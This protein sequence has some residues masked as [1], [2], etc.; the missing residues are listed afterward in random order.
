[1]KVLA[2]RHGALG[3]VIQALGPLQ[4]IRRHH[5][6]AHLVAL[7]GSPFADLLR[8]SGWFQDVWIDDRPPLWRLGSWLGVVRRLRDARFDRVYDLQTSARTAWYFR[9]MGSPPPEWSGVAPGAS[10]RHDNPGRVEMHT[11]E[12]QAEQLRLAGIPDVPPPGLAWLDADVARL[13][14][15]QRFALLVPGGSAHR[16]AKRWPV[17]RYAVLAGALTDLGLVPVV[18]GTREETALVREIAAAAPATV[19]LT[20]RTSIIELAGV[21]RRAALAVGNDTGPMH[22]TAAVSCPSLTLF[23]AESDP[24]RCAPRGRLVGILRRP[25]LADLSVDEVTAAAQRLLTPGSA[26]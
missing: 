19:D 21:A 24:A 13:G 22:V 12:R 23:S 11:A 15:P 3:D 9:L 14:L 7:T 26:R 17:A 1:M 10:H 8:A 6:D 18:A 16:P 2:I 5:P 4:A 25:D 20:G